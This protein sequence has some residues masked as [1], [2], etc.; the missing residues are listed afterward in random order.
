MGGQSRSDLALAEDG[1]GAVWT[2][3]C[4]ARPQP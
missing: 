1:S 4:V 2:G 3:G